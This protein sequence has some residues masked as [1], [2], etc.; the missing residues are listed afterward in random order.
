MSREMIVTVGTSLFKSA[1]W[2]PW[3]EGEGEH[4][5]QMPTPD[6]SHWLE[7][8]LPKSPLLRACD[9]RVRQGLEEMLGD[10]NDTG[11]AEHLPPTLSEPSHGL[12]MKRFS[13]EMTTLLRWADDEDAPGGAGQGL[14]ALLS[15]YDRV[16]V[17]ADEATRDEKGRRLSWTA[18]VHHA[19]YLNHLAE[20]EVAKLHDVDGL[21]SHRPDELQAGLIELGKWV[22]GRLAFDVSREFD[23]MLTGGYKVYS[24]LLSP[25]GY[26]RHGVRFIYGHE[27]AGQLV[28]L[29][30]A[31]IRVGNQSPEHVG[32]ET[33]LPE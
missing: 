27:A 13:A 18:A 17:V 7:R 29:T 6:Y 1:T 16:W 31:Q 5:R 22:R 2:E 3:T 21:A 33:V 26:N 30:G 11:W 28:I 25:L 32:H 23:L 9:G 15:A 19:A 14:R 24:Y 20:R 4:K 12:E 8:D 10:D